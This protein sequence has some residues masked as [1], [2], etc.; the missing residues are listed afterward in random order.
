MAYDD[1]VS[2]ILIGI[3]AF[4]LLLITL[5][6]AVTIYRRA[7]HGKKYKKLDRLRDH[8]MEKVT[9]ILE[10]GKMPEGFAGLASR[11]NSL[12]WQAVESVLHV[13]IADGKYGDQARVL[14]QKL[15]YVDFYEKK[16]K[17]RNRIT[18]ATAV[19]KLGKMRS[20]TSTG[21]LIP[22]LD[23][24][25][26]EIVAVATRSLSKIGSDKG[27]HGILE[28]MPKL[29]SDARITRKTLETSLMNFGPSSLPTLIE[30]GERYTDPM[31]RASIL[32]VL[33][34]MKTREALPFAL[35]NFR[36]ADPEVRSKALKVVGAAGAELPEADKEKA[37]LLLDDPVWF[38]RLQAAKA[39]GN[40]KF[41]KAEDAL[42]AR[43][44]DGSWQ[45][46]NAAAMALTMASDKAADIF[47]RT[48]DSKDRYAKES[49]CEEIEKTNFVA[50]LIDHL[51]SKDKALAGKSAEILKIMHSL[52]YSTPLVEYGKTGP[53]ERIRKEVERILR[54]EPAA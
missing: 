52:N 54:M 31:P 29:L 7:Y 8:Y 37:L 27:L 36:H 40:L 43:L 21:K 22:L 19:D 10:H 25:N 13:F 2:I 14:F 32:E 41:G 9:G 1:R 45:V 4:V 16:A 11:P 38:V 51:D 17:S 15:G 50:K 5:L 42:A 6:L 26:P 35:T 12:A 23:D 47:L 28:R 3:I 34:N 44:L 24:E 39:L 33:S 46:R 30:C 18:K 48:L 53:D 20:E 49:I